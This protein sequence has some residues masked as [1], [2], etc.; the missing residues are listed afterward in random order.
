MQGRRYSE[1]VIWSDRIK[2]KT[3]SM[4]LYPPGTSSNNSRSI[5]A[6]GQSNASSTRFVYLGR[7][8]ADGDNSPGTA[9]SCATAADYSSS[10]RAESAAVPRPRSVRHRPTKRG[11]VARRITTACA[12]TALPTPHTRCIVF[13][14]T[15][16]TDCPRCCNEMLL[17]GLDVQ[18]FTINTTTRCQRDWH[19]L[20]A[21]PT[22]R[23]Q[24]IAPKPCCMA[25]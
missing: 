8:G 4:L 25:S 16:P 3:R 14:K 2:K 6:A 19:L 15:Q 18:A 23:K 10:A 22:S 5:E 7:R 9:I 12:R 17:K 24:Q 13:H 1:G 21:C 11:A 20:C